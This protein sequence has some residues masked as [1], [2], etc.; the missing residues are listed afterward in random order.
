MSCDWPNKDIVNEYELSVFENK[1]LKKYLDPRR[2]KIYNKFN[3]SSIFL[4]NVILPV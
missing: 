3:I 1:V 2:H 4:Q